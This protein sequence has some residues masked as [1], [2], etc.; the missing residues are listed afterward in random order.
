MSTPNSLD[1]ELAGRVAVVT[2]AGRGIGAVTAAL[3]ARR[4]AAVALLDRDEPGAKRVAAEIEQAGGRALAIG[5]DLLDP[6]AIEAAF[7][8]VRDE[9][10][11][12][13]ALVLNHTVHPC[14]SVL[15][16]D[17]GEWDLSLEINLRGTFLCAKAAL[18]SMI[19]RGGGSVVGLASDCVIR[20]C[21]NAAAYVASKAGI[22]ALMRS[23]A[24]DYAADN[25]RANAVTPGATDTPG[26]RGAFS[27]EGRDLEE[28]IARAAGQ[29]P[30]GRLGAP[31]DVAEMI[32]FVCS[33]RAAFVT[34]AELLVDGGMT[35]GY[36]A[37]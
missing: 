35:I 23:I 4:G 22:V 7:A 12:V 30:L 21:R 5:A 10:G 11:G 2:G 27:V 13:D 37:D 24:I 33:D 16:T 31:K 1:D 9:L 25:V 29:S 18:P 8:R 26:L 19:E 32:A 20:S 6:A 34:G 28:S 3:L 14:G 15:E 17:A 36:A